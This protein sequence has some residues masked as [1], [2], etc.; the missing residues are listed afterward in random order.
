VPQTE[1]LRKH[2]LRSHPVKIP[3]FWPDRMQNASHLKKRI[4]K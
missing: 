3:V 2:G 4:K 1:H